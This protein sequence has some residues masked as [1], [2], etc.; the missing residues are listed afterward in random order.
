MSWLRRLAAMA[1]LCGAVTGCGSAATPAASPGPGQTP[2]SRLAAALLT[3]KDFPG[4]FKEDLAGGADNVPGACGMP[5]DPPTTT[6][7]EAQFS[8]GGVK[9]AVFD[10]LISEPPG[11]AKTD[12]DK[13]QAGLGSCH[14]YTRHTSSGPLSFSVWSIDFPKL[15]DQ[16]VALRMLARVNRI[17]LT[18]DLVAVR[19]GDVIAVLGNGGLFL[20][21]SLTQTMLRKQVDRM[22]ASVSG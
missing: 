17:R 6:H 19:K 20:D 13:L 18:Y 11:Q 5:A 2:G 21:D 9:T 15:G 4:G 1:L 7:A 14:Q 3:V 22:P 10:A 12:L 8:K 16:R